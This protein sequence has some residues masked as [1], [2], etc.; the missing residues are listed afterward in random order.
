VT[1][2]VP[3][4][5][6]TESR[7]PPRGRLLIVR[8]PRSRRSPA[9]RTLIEAVRRLEVAGWE[10]ELQTTAAAGHATE[11]A[12][13]AAMQGLDAV[14]ACGG[15]GT[16]R[17]V[18]E[19][20]AHTSTALGVLPAGTANVWAH[21]AH[22]PLRLGAA[23]AL[24][25]RARRLRVDTG[26]AN[27]RRFLLMSSTGLDAAAV[28]DMEGSRAKRVFGRAAYAVA[29]VRHGLLDRGRQARIEVDGVAIERDALMVVAGNTR[30]FGAIARLTAQA[31]MNDGLLDV[32]VLSS[33][34]R[35]GVRWRA[36]TAWGAM[37]GLLPEAAVLGAPGV[38]YLRGARV[39]IEAETPLP[40]QADGEFIGETPLHVEV[41]PASLWVLVAPGAN[42]LFD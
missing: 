32:C 28:R 23:L 29:G 20:V 31:R 8:N 7:L 13:E 24:A 10:I 35:D 33:T 38:D 27:G 30:V 19:G 5:S 4:V 14:L 1:A 22:I 37:R 26:L 40:V 18:A 6:I 15:D 42:P 9:A 21:E 17:E 3:A 16:V 41:D 25:T 34:P 36:E 39:T 2:P 11:L 12:R